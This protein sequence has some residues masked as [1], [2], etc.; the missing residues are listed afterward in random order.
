MPRKAKAASQIFKNDWAACPK[1]TVPTKSEA[2]APIP[3]A[4]PNRNPLGRLIIKKSVA[5]KM[6]IAAAVMYS[7]EGASMF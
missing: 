2:A 1:L 3:A 5:A 7:K 4:Y 6:A